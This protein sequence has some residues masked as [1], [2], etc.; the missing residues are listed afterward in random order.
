MTAPVAAQD[1]PLSQILIEG[2]G[3]HAVG[4]GYDSVRRL[5][6]DREG[7]VYV[8]YVR[9]GQS[10]VD[11]IDAKGTLSSI[12][13][14]REG[15]KRPYVPTV[16]S[17]SG[18]S[19]FVNPDKESVHVSGPSPEGAKELGFHVPGLTRPSCLVLSP[20]EGT[21]FVGDA[22]SGALWAFRVEKDGVLKFG[23]PYGRARPRPGQKTI[24][25]TGLTVDVSGRIYAA[26]PLGV[27]MFDPT[28]RLSGVLLP[29]ERADVT[30][31]IFGG[32]ERDRLYVLC[33]DKVYSRKV[34]AKGIA[35]EK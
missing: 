27:Q 26:T 34:R 17:R 6:A 15:K 28:G 24:A 5:Y 7:N 12:E 31:V 16:Q 35:A 29:P 21:L 10:G 23:E 3:W 33:G 25:I 32:P 2:E 22:Q 30:A 13:E 8:D 1:M 20:D 9:K 19:F 11:R 18:Y 14:P 4:R